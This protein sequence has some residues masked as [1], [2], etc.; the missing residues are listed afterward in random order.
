MA[1]VSASKGM[2]DM[3]TAAYVVDIRTVRENVQ[4]QGVDEGCG[5]YPRKREGIGGGKLTRTASR[6]G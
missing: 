3:L 4:W 6:A 2:P 1:D 5:G